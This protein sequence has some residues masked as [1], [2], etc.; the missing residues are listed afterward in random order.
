MDHGEVSSTGAMARV[1]IPRSVSGTWGFR[2]CLD[3][4]M[5]CDVGVILSCHVMLTVKLESGGW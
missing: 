5:F 1:M 4:G 3:F 2:L